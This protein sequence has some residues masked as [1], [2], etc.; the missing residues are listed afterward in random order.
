MTGDRQ[1]TSVVLRAGEQRVIPLRALATAGYRW[2]A[3]VGGPRPEAVEV[4][5]RRGELPPASP[6]GQSV[7]EEALLSGRSPGRASVRLELRRPWETLPVETI[8]LEVE[9]RA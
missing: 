2:F 4:E 1:A 9:V 8:E 7:P 6:P 5:L 3:S